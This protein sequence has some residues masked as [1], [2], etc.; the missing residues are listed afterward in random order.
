MISN[1]SPGT[2]QYIK[3]SETEIL[4]IF[5]PSFSSSTSFP[6][7]KYTFADL[8]SS[9]NK[10]NRKDIKMHYHPNHSTS[11]YN[12]SKVNILYSGFAIIDEEKDLIN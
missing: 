6:V 2:Y 7:N 3:P 1:E 12:P 5:N 4:D 11:L 9:I 8:D 10:G